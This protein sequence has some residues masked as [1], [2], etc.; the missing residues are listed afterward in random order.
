[1]IATHL[2]H[3]IYRY[4]YNFTPLAVLTYGEAVVFNFVFA[5]MCA[6]LIYWLIC[7]LP[8]C[9][10]HFIQRSFYYLTGEILVSTTMA[11][12]NH[13]LKSMGQKVIKVS[14]KD[15]LNNTQ[16]QYENGPPLFLISDS[17]KV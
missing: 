1:M 15:V 9:I 14:W 3:T 12:L 5:S 11:V 4:Y 8:T 6:V 10:V 2:P 13:D 7:T 16:A 17:M